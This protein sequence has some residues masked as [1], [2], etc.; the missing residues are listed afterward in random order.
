MH[1]GNTIIMQAPKEAIFETAAN[2]ELWPK[3]LPHY[4]YITYLQRGRDA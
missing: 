4:R 3:I 2:L 1:T